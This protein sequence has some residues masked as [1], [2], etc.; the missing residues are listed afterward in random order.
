MTSQ[1]IFGYENAK[2]IKGESL[3]YITAIRYLAPANESGTNVCPNAGACASVCLYEAGRGAF[4]NVKAARVAKTIHRLEHRDEHLVLAAAEIIRATKRAS[5]MG[6]TLAVRLNGTSDLPGD[7]L[8]LAKQFPNVQFYDYTKLKTWRN[9]LPANYHLTLSYDPQTVPA[10]ECQ[11][12]L[13]KG[14]NVAVVFDIKKG[15][16]LPTT[17]LSVPV[18]DGDEHD[19]RFLDPVGVVVGLR[20]KGPAKGSAFAVVVE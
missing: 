2:T 15:D 11:K 14:V 8:A 9:A 19:L 13:A 5:V 17:F 18:I 16:A 7:A 12:A 20:A 6:M 1:A 4:A 3:G 10:V